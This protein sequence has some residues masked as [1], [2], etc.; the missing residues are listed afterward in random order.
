M[1]ERLYDIIRRTDFTG[2]SLIT[3]QRCINITLSDDTASFMVDDVLESHEDVDI[4]SIVAENTEQHAVIFDGSRLEIVNVD[5]I[6][7]QTEKGLL[8]FAV[9]AEGP[10]TATI[11]EASPEYTSTLGT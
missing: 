1:A 6:G 11:E 10:V 2:Y 7:V 4:F 8:T 9:V 3:N 5:Q